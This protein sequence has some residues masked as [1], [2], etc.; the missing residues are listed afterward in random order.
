MQQRVALA[1]SLVIQPEIILLDEPLSALDAK[2]R[3]Q[4]QDELKKLHKNLGITFILVTHDQEE[5]L[6][7]SDKV[8]VMSN[9]QIEQVGKPSDIYDSP[10]S[11]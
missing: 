4:L 5:A 11:L 3:K 2:V 9:G 10:N 6:S 1:R 8:V 7:L